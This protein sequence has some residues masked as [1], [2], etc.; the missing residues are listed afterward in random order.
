MSDVSAHDYV[1]VGAGSAGCVR[2]A[3]LSEDPDARVLLLE[4]GP[5]DDRPEAHIPFL[6]PLLLKSGYDWDLLGEREPGLDGR[7]LYLPRG[8]MLGGCSSINAML[9]VRGNRADYD[10]WAASGAD[11]WSYEQV[12]PYFRRAEDNERGESEYHGVGGPLKVS[13]GRS[14]NALVDAMLE[15]AKAAGH[16]F[17]PDVNGAR[18]EGV[19]Y[20]QATQR[21]GFRDSTADAYLRPALARENLTV[22]TGTMTARVLFSGARAT[23]VE[24]IRSGQIEEIRA[25]R[26]VI[27]CAGAYQSPVLL[28]LSG[29]GPEEQLAPWGI[30]LREA[31]P[32]GENL[33]DHAMA[34][35]NWYCQGGSLFDAPAPENFARFEADHE[36]PLTSTI[37][38][39][40]GF[41]RTRPGLEAPDVQFHFA[42]SLLTDEGLSPPAGHG[43]CFGPVA[44]KPASRGRVTL[45]SPVPDAKPRVLCN[46]LTHDDDVRSMIAGVRLA[47]EIARQEPLRA[48]DAGACSVPASDSD[49]D[50][51]AWVRA[52]THP[53]YH[54]TS[55]C[56]IGTVVDPELRVYGCEGLR[57]VDA[58]VMPTITRGNTNAPTIMIAERAADLIKSANGSLT[59]AATASQP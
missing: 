40:V 31:L 48:V 27:V 7:R 51:H 46:F 55:T 53:V 12:L 30:E 14:R 44:I 43:Y 34:Q 6:W 52:V 23:G 41:F 16:E 39:G 45:R 15:A 38:E 59:A 10:G 5:A 17:N 33:Q 29:I 50:I 25:E 32:V 4:A 9:Y 13:E 35:L 26:E 3:R 36:G 57:V 21:D 22:L 58:S 8:K 20:F 2:A 28:M 37:P 54:P 42:P 19:A 56:A 18:Q 49:A 11:G 47:L 1:I 24:V